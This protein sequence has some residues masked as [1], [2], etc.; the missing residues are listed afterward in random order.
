MLELVNLNLNM[1]LLLKSLEDHS[2]ETMIQS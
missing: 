2:N 1:A